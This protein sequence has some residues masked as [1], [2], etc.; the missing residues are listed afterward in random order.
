MTSLNRLAIIG[1]G[2]GTTAEFVVMATEDGELPAHVVLII[3]NNS[4]SGI[5]EVAARH[6]IRS[7]H[8]STATHPRDADRDTA[9]LEA[10]TDAGVDLIVLAGYMKKIGPRVL[11]AYKGRIVNTHPSLLPAYGSTGMYG[12]RVH[13]A[14]LA[15]HAPVTGATVHLVTENYDEGPILDNSLFQ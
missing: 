3:G 14:V 13:A 9:M 4:R 12:D 10:L 11:A 2:V 6:Q 7:I 5:F 8:L 15:D 1:S